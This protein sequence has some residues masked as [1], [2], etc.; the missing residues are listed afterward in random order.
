MAEQASDAEI[1][2]AGLERLRHLGFDVPEGEEQR[3]ALA[4]ELGSEV[5]AALER[6]GI[7]SPASGPKAASEEVRVLMDLLFD[8]SEPAA[9]VSDPLF[10]A[11]LLKQ[12]ALSL[13]H[14]N[15]SASPY[16]YMAYAVL[17]VSRERAYQEAYELGRAALLVS[18][19][20]PRGDVSCR[21]YEMF[22]GHIG[23]YREP[24]RAAREQ[25]ERS[26]RDGIA[27]GEQIYAPCAALHLAALRLGAGDD[28]DEVRAA[29][30]ACFELARRFNAQFAVDFLLITRQ[31]VA[32]LQGRTLGLLSLDDDTFREAAFVAAREGDGPSLE[33]HWLRIAKLMLAVFSGD[34]QG[35][36]SIALA[37]DEDPVSAG[38]AY[39]LTEQSFYTGLALASTGA[40]GGPHAAVLARHRDRLALWAAGCPGNFRHKRALV[41]AELARAGGADEE[42]LKLYNEAAE[43]AR[44]GGFVHHEALANE[45]LAKLCLRMGRDEEARS[46]FN[47][48]GRAYARW[49][50][51][52]K[53]KDWPEG[54][55]A[56]S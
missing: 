10:N 55:S 56:G 20:L 36:V 14:G 23:F 43:G 44:E 19:A 47:A 53:L 17:L 9:S 52:A 30:E 39:F 3:E 42:A 24:I 46:S 54:G 31:T 33:R 8:L 37:A 6:S 51:S 15:T 41:D 12:V 7:A 32:A 22:G 34:L 50:A 13:E 45:L 18:E 16:S 21:V 4:R 40:A 27:A 11:L 49:G 38:A 48:A 5:R 1:V 2:G 29:T 28:L 35:G 26:C 25:L